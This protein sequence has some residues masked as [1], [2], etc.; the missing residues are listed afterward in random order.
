M[1]ILSLTTIYPN[2][3]NMAEGRSVAFL[4]RALADLGVEGT[5]LVLKPWVPRWLARRTDR[6]RHLALR[7]RVENRNG[8]RVVFSR[9]AHIPPRYRLD[10]CV[11]S[12][13]C[14][15]IGL[16]KKIRG[17]FDLVHGQS[18]YPSAPAAR[19][20]A[21][22]LRIPFIITLRDDL[23]H[24]TDLYTRPEAGPTFEPLF[25]SVS[26]VFAHG[27][28]IQ[29]EASCFF[30]RVTIPVILAPNGVDFQGIS[31]ILQD[32]SPVEEHPWGEI[33]SVGNLFRFKGI[34]ENLQALKQMNEQ[35][36][37]QWRYTIVGDGP[38]R[39]ELQS[40]AKRLGLGD[41]VRFT[42][43]L[44]HREAIRLVYGADIFSLPSWAEAFGNVYAEA[45]VCGKPVVG[46]RGYGAEVTVRDG[47]TGLLVPPKDVG[48][49]AG[50]LSFLLSYP[51]KAREM[52]AQ[53][54]RHIGE[55]TWERTAQ[56][57]TQT[58]RQ[59]LSKD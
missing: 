51:E 29:R 27:P 53:G 49:L 45:A 39:Q 1:R 26:A 42:G 38:Y 6:W 22:H 56:I 41:R 20:I 9:Y 33:I 57:Y 16:I 46:C 30:Q 50:A 43:T 52:G 11:Y 32:R 10:L 24:L 40:L 17:Q 31:E 12:M 47:E 4:D 48:A 14:R 59:V 36:L 13:A 5:T 34:H 25:N 21:R 44:P 28:A 19:I 55:F 54:R 8:G 3:Q 7:P 18:I 2:E 37:T 35:G 23:S 15:A 58:I